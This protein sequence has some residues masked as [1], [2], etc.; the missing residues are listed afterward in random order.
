MLKHRK[1]SG[2]DFLKPA[3]C[4][5]DEIE[6]EEVYV[7]PE[8]LSVKCINCGDYVFAREVEQHS[9][10]CSHVKLSEV[11][12]EPVTGIKGKIQKLECSLT[13]GLGLCVTAG[14]R[15][16]L[17]VLTRL[18][19]QL[20][21]VN[22]AED[23]SVNHKTEESLTCL[24][25]LFKGTE[26][27]KLYAERL[28]ALARDQD[29]EVS[30]QCMQTKISM[31]QRQVQHYKDKA[32]GLK[33]SVEAIS[34][35]R[36]FE[37][38]KQFIDNLSSDLGSK[39]SSFDFSSVGKSELSF[40]FEPPSKTVGILGDPKRLFYS[41]CLTIKLSFPL[42]SPAHSIPISKLYRLALNQQV[43]VESWGDFIKSS[44]I[45][46]ERALED[47]AQPR[48]MKTLYEDLRE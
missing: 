23:L 16:Y 20:S 47:G 40:S 38:T 7:V 12:S 17:T 26:V 44:L 5:E 29:R 43:P 36:R 46:A 3:W 39:E 27:L 2:F 42:K 10:L 34:Q 11:D 13:Q 31:L 14:D 32:E 1:L 37:G 30:S 33:N 15:N 8:Q 22:S 35:S 41:K 25:T 21:S 48:R 45:G 18:C 9:R 19:Q 28:R 6:C 4:T 24:I